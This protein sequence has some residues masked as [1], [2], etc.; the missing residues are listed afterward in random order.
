MAIRQSG[1]SCIGRPSDRAGLAFAVEFLHNWP[2]DRAIIV[3][4]ENDQKADG[5]WP[6]RAGAE[7]FATNLAGMLNRP[8]LWSLPPEGYKDSRQWMTSCHGINAWSE[9]GGFYTEY[10]LQNAHTVKPA[11]KAF[12][13]GGGGGGHVSDRR[14]IIV[15]TDEYR[16]TDEAITALAHDPGIFHRAGMLVQVVANETEMKQVSVRRA[17]NHPF[18]RELPPATLRESLTKHADWIM[19]RPTGIVSIHPPQWCVQQVSARGHWPQLRFL[20]AVINHPIV[21]PDGRLLATSGYEAD[22][23]LYLDIPESLTVDVP[24]DP[25]KDDVIQARNALVDIVHEFPFKAKAHISAWISALLTPLSRFSFDGPAPLF[26]IDA[27]TR[28][29]GKGLLADIIS[30][31]LTGDKFP[32]MTY[33]HEVAEM[34]KIITSLAAEGERLVLLDNIIGPFGNSALDAAVTST[35]WK[36]RYLGINRLYEGPLHL[37]WY[38]TGN[39]VQLVGDT[40][41][42]VMHIHLQTLLEK[43]ELREGLKYPQLR[44]YVS[45]HRRLLLSAALTMLRGWFAAGSPDYRLSPW[46]SFEGWTHVV[47]N[48]L[49]HADM[50]DPGET[51]AAM[52]SFSDRNAEMLDALL[53]NLEN[54]FP[55]RHTFSA[56]EVLKVANSVAPTPQQTAL[57]ESVKELLPASNATNLGCL[58]R[59][60]QERNFG[61]L[62]LVKHGT[63]QGT[64][65]W[66]IDRVHNRSNDQIDVHHPHDVHSMRCHQDDAA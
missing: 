66:S 15:G 31:I 46:G 29:A 21:L 63:V 8:V 3:V 61:G 42:R 38:A 13:G 57:L 1:L 32:V 5:N 24:A 56:S 4:G 43:P 11:G 28:G 37:T 27:N 18:I 65:R 50:I 62:R 54:L 2:I 17:Y 45:T 26:L 9:K 60:N 34:R 44:R 59:D 10:L 41:R 23:Q 53:F 6:G 12:G 39:N 49:V 36:D 48:I 35:N 55:N 16:V 22:S 7:Y 30:L 51:R 64:V 14:E 33:S 47:R 58:F 20:N 25:S 40:S 52:Q 19:H